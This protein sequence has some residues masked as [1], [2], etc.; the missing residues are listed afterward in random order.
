[1]ENPDEIRGINSRKELAAVS[2]I[3]QQQRNETLMAAG[4]TIEDPDTTYVGPD[5]EVG[6]D[7]VLHPNVY[8][9]GRTRIGANCEIHANVRIVDSTLAD[10]VEVLN[11]CVITGAR[12]AR[13]A[14]IGPFAHLR[15]QAD[16]REAAHVGNFV[17]LK[18]TVLGARS[19]ANHLTYLGDATVGEGVNVG[20]GTITCNYDGAHKHPTFV[21]DGAFVGSD[22]TL[23]APVRIGR[24]AYVAAGSSIV[25][26][27]PPGALG[28][29]R[30]VQVNK[31][32][33]VEKRKR[34][35]T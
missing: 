14:R 27:V 21:D 20:A 29:A 10:H 18:R 17:E 25:K 33:W 9:E 23:V 34:K 13:G 35:K 12:I 28:I 24:N 6:T 19:K 5:V 16:V 2:R 8:L 1:V 30:G 4:V 15:P 26:D 11:F 3:V 7:T 22:T 32:G 31:E